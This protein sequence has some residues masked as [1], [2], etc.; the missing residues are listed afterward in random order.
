MIL[1]SLTLDDL[2]EAFVRFGTDI[3]GRYL[4]FFIIVALVETV[5]VTMLHAC[6]GHGFRLNW[7]FGSNVLLPKDARHK[8]LNQESNLKTKLRVSYLKKKE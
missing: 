5:L 3:Y 4:Y 8:M 6:M 2:F 7:L 1:P